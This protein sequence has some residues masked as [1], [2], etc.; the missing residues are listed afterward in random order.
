[1]YLKLTHFTYYF[2]FLTFF[3]LNYL[4]FEYEKY[5]SLYMIL[6]LK[7]TISYRIWLVSFKSKNTLE[8]FP[9]DQIILTGENLLRCNNLSL[10]YFRLNRMN[11]TLRSK[12]RQILKSSSIVIVCKFSS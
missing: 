5:L 1:M 3:L 4:Y 8:L 6:L 11:I 7:I 2:F 9:L 12:I 10:V